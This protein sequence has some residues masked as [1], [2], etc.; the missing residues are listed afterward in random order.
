MGFEEGLSNTYFKYL[1]MFYM[2]MCQRIN[3][4]ISKKEEIFNLVT[5]EMSTR[6]IVLW[7]KRH[8]PENLR[9]DPYANALVSNDVEN[10]YKE[11]EKYYLAH[12]SH[13]KLSK[14]IDTYQRVANIISQLFFY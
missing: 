14:V 10:V 3:N 1:G 8:L 12:K 11:I 9:K 4:G 2:E 13:F 6:P 7:A 5:Q